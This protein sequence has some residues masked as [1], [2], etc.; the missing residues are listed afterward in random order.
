M[1]GLDKRS[2]KRETNTLDPIKCRRH[3]VVLLEVGGRVLRI[4]VKGD[5]QWY[6]VPFDEIYRMGCRIRAQELKEERQRRRELS[7]VIR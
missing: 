2:V 1:T 7:R 3:L 5:R 6:T 4:K